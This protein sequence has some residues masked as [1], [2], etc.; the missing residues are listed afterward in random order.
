[1][2]LR[3]TAN[4]TD[5]GAN[6]CEASRLTNETLT[7]CSADEFFTREAAPRPISRS[8]RLRAYRLEEEVADSCDAAT[9]QANK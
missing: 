5:V 8:S 3:Q 4:D 6:A 2:H 7:G 1:M 9:R